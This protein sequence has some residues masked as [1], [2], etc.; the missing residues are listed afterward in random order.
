MRDSESGWIRL[1]PGEFFLLWSSLGLGEPPAV[2]GIP[3]IGRTR[4]ARA[5]FERTAD[6][7]LSERELGTVSR[8]DRDLAGMLRAVA[9][10]DV[11]LDMSAEWAG[12]EFRAVGA[13]LGQQCVT[14]G[15]SGTELRIGPVRGSALVSTMLAAVPE[16]PAG[17]G[18]PANVRAADYAAAC[19]AGRRDGTNGFSDSLRSAGLRPA[20]VNTLV[21]AVTGRAGGGQFGGG[22]RGRGGRWSRGAGSVNWVDTEQGRFALSR[23][24]DWVTATPADPARLRTM[25]E[26]LAADLIG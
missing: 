10:A 5:E 20:E 14:V 21:R 15:V 12:P 7:G 3:H 16:L 18:A 1:H 19:A 26:Q 22:C 17:H 11:L 24:G 6:A 4:A 13:V 23:T 25:V 2:L 9:G 8:P